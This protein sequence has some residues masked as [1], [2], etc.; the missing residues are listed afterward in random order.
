VF[1]LL[2]SCVEKDP[3]QP[4]YL[5]SSA[6]ILTHFLSKD[7]YAVASVGDLVAAV[8]I[9]SSYSDSR[10]YENLYENYFVQRVE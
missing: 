6:T 8:S 10:V 2:V 9:S 4:P 3:D 7:A 5:F 1:I